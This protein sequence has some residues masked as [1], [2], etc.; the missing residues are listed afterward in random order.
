MQIRA[1]IILMVA[2]LA[3]L[4]AVFLVRT[5]IE[6]QVE[7]LPPEVV[8]V[9]TVPV[10]AARTDIE[11]GTRLNEL[12]LNVVDWP[13]KSLPD[14]YFSSIA[15][16][17]GDE[18]PAALTRIAKGEAILHYKLSPH[19]ARGGLP[20]KIPEEMRAI[21]IAV[22]DIRGVAGFV[23]PGTFVDVLHTTTAGR[24]DDRPVTRVLLQNLRVLGVDQVDSEDETKP[25][26]VRAI[27]L[28]VSLEDGQKLTLASALG[29][30]SLLLRNEYDTAILNIA[31]V[32]L[33]DLITA[34]ED[35]PVRQVQVP[36]P[37]AAPAAPRPAPRRA[38]PPR[39]TVEV[40]R[41]LDIQ[42]Q[43]VTEGREM[44]MTTDSATPTTAQ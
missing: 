2:L 34:Q 15:E 30:L 20:L 1:L 22:N 41:G 13:E 38:P 39:P 14:N 8:T 18:P 27:T 7:T 26:V 12:M 28:L 3:G 23:L 19:G 16:L 36:P 21:T 33:Q 4:A 6:Q 31:T 40:I 37:V 35:P 5:V 11:T 10:V 9:K 24:P 17:L 29:E 32:T 43:I 42:T 44:P 25:K